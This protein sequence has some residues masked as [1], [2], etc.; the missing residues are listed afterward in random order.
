MATSP[1]D[2]QTS[3]VYKINY[4]DY[5]NS[6]FNVKVLYAEQKSEHEYF[7]DIYIYEIVCS[8]FTTKKYLQK[9]SWSQMIFVQYV[10]KTL[11]SG[12][13]HAGVPDSLHQKML[14]EG[15]QGQYTVSK[16]DSQRTV[17]KWDSQWVSSINQTAF[18]CA[19]RGT[20]GAVV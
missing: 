5:Q 14:K 6:V 9:H 1:L 10:W 19:R 8:V 4:G 7:L 13:S 20:G 18:V 15:T 2:L 12:F 3:P 11:Q 16:W 17:S